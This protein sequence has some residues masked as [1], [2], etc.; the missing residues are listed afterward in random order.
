MST[1][2]RKVCRI[3]EVEKE[4]SAFHPN[5]SCSLGVTGTC[6]ICTNRRKSM[7]YNDNR[8]ARQMEARE[9][10]RK[11]KLAAIER[12]GGKCKDCDNSFPPCVFEFH[13]LDPS[14]KDVN[15]SAAMFAPKWERELDKCVMLCANCHRIRHHIMREDSDHAKEVD[16]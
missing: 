8:A 2:S 3:C 11:R 12:F 10:G 4:L 7:W 15:P 5:K 6:R 13:H 1:I 16:K 9:R 14:K